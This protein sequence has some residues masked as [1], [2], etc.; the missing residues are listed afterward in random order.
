ME[1][2]TRITSSELS[3]LWTGYMQDSLSICTFKYFLQTVENADI[4]PIIQQA[5]T[6]SEAHIL[7]LT[8]LFQSDNR[9]VPFGFTDQDVNL[10]APRLFSDEFMLSNIHQTA[11]MGMIMYA[12]ALAL[13][14][15]EDIRG[16]FSQCLKENDELYNQAVD[17]L[18][19]KG[20][21]IH[22]P[23]MDTPD[24]VDFVSKQSFLAGWFGEQRPLLSVEIANLYANTQRNALGAHLITGYSQVAK[25]KKVQ[26]Y[27][28]KG[29]DIS[30]KHVRKFT[31]IL[32][33][34]NL[35][36]SMIPDEPVTNSTVS[37]FSDK[38]MLFQVLKMNSLGLAYYGTSVA[39][40]LRHDL[41]ALYP[42]LMVDVAKYVEDGSN[43]MI[44]NGWFEEP[45][46][47]LDHN[48]L[49]KD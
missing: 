21:Y 29:K 25:S 49:A 15:R 7:K 22:S 8:A 33:K 30:S 6:I 44:E 10:K 32:Q 2:D 41:A 28:K 31:S 38:L 11:Q 1:H 16:Y 23:F 18:L 5:L 34:N 42:R 12:Q 45:P 27:F 35:P 19:A 26:Q 17:L 43:L 4:R 20:L 39:S 24:Q 40:A 48:Q 14:A 9:P 13:S 47:M 46:R 3:Q 36:A 37:P